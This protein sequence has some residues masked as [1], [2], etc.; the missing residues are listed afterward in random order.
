MRKSYQLMIDAWSHIAPPKYRDLLRKA[1][2]KECAYMIDT[3][4]PLFDMDTR[5]RIM[6]KYQ[7]LVQVI[8]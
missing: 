4:P 3:F 5:F 8:T 1:A 2:P 7:G 6:D